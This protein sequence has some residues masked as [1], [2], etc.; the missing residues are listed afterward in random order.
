MTRNAR[1]TARHREL[2]RRPGR[3]VEGDLLFDDPDRPDHRR[4]ARP[5]AE[6]HPN[7]DLSSS[8]RR[9]CGRLN[10]R[11]DARE[12]HRLS[13]QQRADRVASL[14]EQWTRAMRCGRATLTKA[15]NETGP[16]A[17]HWW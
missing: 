11:V 12:S 4:R 14:E 10:A 16:I 13:R 2:R 6:R 8:V 17:G 3:D 1:E 5:L 7:A 15:G 9:G